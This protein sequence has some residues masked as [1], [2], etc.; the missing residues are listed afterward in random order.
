M[1][2]CFY[3]IFNDKVFQV[4]PTKNQFTPP[5]QPLQGV[6]GFREALFGCFDNL[7]ILIAA[8]LCPI[9]RILDSQVTAG[10]IK[11]DETCGA[12]CFIF[13]CPGIYLCFVHPCR[14]G[15]IRR[16]LGGNGDCSCG[17]WCAIL[18]CTLC[19]IAQEARETDKAVNAQTGIC[20]DLTQYGTSDPIGAPVQVQLVSA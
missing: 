14:R 10:V 15:A 20:C 8:W 17:D 19:S 5:P 9:F 16:E 13:L 11:R 7:T 6:V 2:C 4:K 1:A 18:W 3:P 12:C